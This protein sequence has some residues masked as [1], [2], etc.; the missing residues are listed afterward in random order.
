MAK[1]RFQESHELHGS[2]STWYQVRYHYSGPT[3]HG[4]GTI[5][6]WYYRTTYLVPAGY[7]TTRYQYDWYLVPGSSTGSNGTWYY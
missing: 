4:T 2:T 3:Y 5:P 1:R 7:R 6:T